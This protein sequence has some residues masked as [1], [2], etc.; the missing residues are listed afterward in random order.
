[1]QDA[2]GSLE[3]DCQTNDELA[4]T[5][6]AETVYPRNDPRMYFCVREGFSNTQITEGFCKHVKVTSE[7]LN[8]RVVI[9]AWYNRNLDIGD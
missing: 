5:I 1:M 3:S 4:E 6:S 9:D 2:I 8:G 7:M